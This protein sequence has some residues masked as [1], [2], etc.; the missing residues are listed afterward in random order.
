MIAP[1]C[2]AGKTFVVAEKRPKN[3]AE[4]RESN[5]ELVKPAHEK[6]QIRTIAGHRAER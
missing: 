3:A 1:A 4:C 6:A 2:P 5:H